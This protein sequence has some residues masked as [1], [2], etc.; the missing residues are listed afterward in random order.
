MTKRLRKTGN[1]QNVK[2]WT[3]HLMAFRP[4]RRCHDRAWANYLKAIRRSGGGFNKVPA[5][6]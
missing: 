5:A 4:T 2:D 1:A 3:L 6:R